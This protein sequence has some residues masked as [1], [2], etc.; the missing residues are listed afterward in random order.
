MISFQSIWLLDQEAPYILTWR[1]QPRRYVDKHG[2]L[3]HLKFTFESKGE[4]IKEEAMHFSSLA[5]LKCFELF[6]TIFV[7]LATSRVLPT[8]AF[9]R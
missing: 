5:V 7:V 2:Y 4:G 6:E 1:S 9:K 8:L 3:S